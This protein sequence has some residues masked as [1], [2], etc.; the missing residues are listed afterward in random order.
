MILSVADK[1]RGIGD[2]VPRLCQ[3]PRP[4][5]LQGR[6][7][8]IISKTNEIDTKKR[9]NHYTATHSISFLQPKI[10]IARLRL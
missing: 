4:L 6:K 3:N 1:M 10:L 5:N 2:A 9:N 8:V 7:D